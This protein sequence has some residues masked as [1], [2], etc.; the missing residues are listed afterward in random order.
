MNK[1]VILL[2]ALLGVSLF[3]ACET[4]KQQEATAATTPADSLKQIINQKDT[5]L[6]DMVTT[7]NEIQEGFRQINEAQGRIS[8]ERR[9]GEQNNREA[10]IEDMQ[11]IRRTLKL[12][13]EL[14]ANLRQ[15]V[16]S[17]KSNNSK[18][19]ATMEAT[20]SSLNAQLTD[21]NKQAEDLRAQ[22]AQK[23]IKIAEQGQ[24]I[25]NLKGNVNELSVQNETKARTVSA[26][27]R[28]LNTAFYVFGT[29]RE[30]KE[31]NILQGG[32]VLRNGNYNKDYFTK[33]DIRVDRIIHLYS[34]SAKL[35]TAH[36][37][38]SYTLDRDAQG[39]YTLRITDPNRFWSVSK[40]LVIVVK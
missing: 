2:V 1:I 18:L 7:L 10:I 24:Q 4:K 29:K 33:I 39:Q 27:D 22:L 19:R 35:M 5:E 40:Y 28:E 21:L 36:P 8:V 30:L 16:K 17:S 20:I 6:N 34:K 26:Q 9:K 32:E 14:I 13:S 37:E 3:T 15:Q 25:D 12:N 31:Q 38:G 23:D 11:L